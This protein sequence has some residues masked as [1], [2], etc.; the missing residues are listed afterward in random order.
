MTSTAR[1]DRGVRLGRLRSRR[2]RRAVG[3]RVGPRGR[4]GDKGDIGDPAAVVPGCVHAAAGAAGAVMR[5]DRARHEHCRGKRNGRFQWGVH[6]CSFHRVGALAPVG[7]ARLETRRR[8]RNDA[9]RPSAC[10]R[11]YSDVIA[12]R[13]RS[14]RCNRAGGSR[15]LT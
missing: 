13:G 10:R 2:D 3:L 6:R 4:G 14:T 11:E 9:R 15:R 8:G 12:T 5:V 1:G 7:S